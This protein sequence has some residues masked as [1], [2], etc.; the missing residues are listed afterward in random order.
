MQNTCHNGDILPVFVSRDPNGYVTEALHYPL[1]MAQL[2]YKVTSL[3]VHTLNSNSIN[4]KTKLNAI[5]A[6]S[7]RV[8]KV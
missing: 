5:I 4:I 3:T 1:S 8:N 7:G 6:Q 2:R